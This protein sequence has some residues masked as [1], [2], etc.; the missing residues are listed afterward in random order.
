MSSSSPSVQSSTPEQPISTTITLETLQAYLGYQFRNPT[1]LAQALTHRSLL[2]LR[3]RGLQSNERLEFLGDAVLALLISNDLYRI[4]PTDTEG[5]LSKRRTRL[6]NTDALA[7]LARHHQLGRWLRMSKGEAQS[8]GADRTSLLSNLIEALLGAAFIDGG[9]SAA[10]Q[11]YT[12]LQL[13]P[14]QRP[15]EHPVDD[16]KSALQELIAKRWKQTPT[17]HLER[18]E[19]PP[20]APWFTVSVLLETRVLATGQGRRRKEAEQAASRQALRT[21]QDWDVSRQEEPLAVRKTIAPPCR[22]SPKVH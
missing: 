20:H 7:T 10:R 17:Y 12:A 5:Q 2:T 9:L 1:L 15:P 16:P 13:P 8:G 22:D 3:R 21:V 4:H 11:V 6:V 18:I 14:N 19:G